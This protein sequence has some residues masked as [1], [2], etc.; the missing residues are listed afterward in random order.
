M[1]PSHPNPT[2]LEQLQNERFRFELI[3]NRNPKFVESAFDEVYQQTGAVIDLLENKYPSV[4]SLITTCYFVGCM[5]EETEHNCKKSY[6]AASAKLGVG[7]EEASRRWE[8]NQQE[9][10]QAGLGSD[11]CVVASPPASLEFFAGPRPGSRSARFTSVSS[12][13]CPLFL[14]CT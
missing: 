5:D 6:M 1:V 11:D 2:I 8:E 10:R 13:L 4:G 9:Y 14:P 12:V 3:I 7:E